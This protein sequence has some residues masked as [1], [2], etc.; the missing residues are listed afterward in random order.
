MLANLRIVIH[1]GAFHLLDEIGDGNATWTGVGAVEDGTA[2]PYTVTLAQN[3]QTFRAALVEAI[4]DE[5][6][7]VDN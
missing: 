1:N 3:A 5:A 7:C 2:T 6:M 4:K